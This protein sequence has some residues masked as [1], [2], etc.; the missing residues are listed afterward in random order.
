ML[1]KEALYDNA[2]QLKR[3]VNILREENGKLKAKIQQ[4]DEENM[5]KGKLMEE[6]MH[7][8]SIAGNA[9][10]MPRAHKE[11]SLINA[12]KKKIKEFETENLQL[13]D[14][15]A[16]L[17]KNIKLTKQKEL[18]VIKEI[19]KLIEHCSSLRS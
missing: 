1:D 4:Y 5:K 15:N 3:A 11:S 18:E 16:V 17:C 9:S 2:L 8:L 13:K 19:N 12:L 6:M 10:V 7:Q 14:A